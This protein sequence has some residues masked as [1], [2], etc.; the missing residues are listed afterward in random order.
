[1]L[2]PA[3]QPPSITKGTIPTRRPWNINGEPEIQLITK[4]VNLMKFKVIN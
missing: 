3:L 2:R 4:L 1:M